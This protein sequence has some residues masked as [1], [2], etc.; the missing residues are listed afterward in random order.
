MF[1]RTA[2]VL[3]IGLPLALLVGIGWIGLSELREGLDRTGEDIAGLQTGLAEARK[4]VAAAR[5]ARQAKSRA[6]EKL[7]A[8][9]DTLE[10]Q[11]AT[12]ESSLSRAKQEAARLAQDH[13][14]AL[15][16]IEGRLAVKDAESKRLSRELTDARAAAATAAPTIAGQK[17]AILQLNS[18]LAA[19]RKELRDASRENDGLKAQVAQLRRAA[20]SRLPVTS[21]PTPKP[22]TP[23]KSL[24]R[25]EK[26]LAD[27]R[28]DIA[29]MRFYLSRLR[30][31]HPA[32][33]RQIIGGPRPAAPKKTLAGKVTA[34]DKTLGLVV[35]NI[36]KGQGIQKGYVLTV[37][38]GGKLIG[39]VRV[40]EVFPDASTTTYVPKEM[41]GDPQIGDDVTTEGR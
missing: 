28:R 7:A 34:V 14:R 12:A 24:S 6:M 11:V 29:R 23:P 1:T 8:Q 32:V 3:A 31:E 21:K 10:Q 41:K 13:S 19:L 33:Y 30:D 4:E 40:D 9:I 5:K 20:G 25:I 27:A 18:G 17:D 37:Q 35:T 2:A 39:K 38:R 26:E 16:Q 36:G 22:D 15:A